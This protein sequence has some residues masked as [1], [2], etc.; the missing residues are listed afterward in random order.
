MTSV[1][2]L[3]LCALA[4]AGAVAMFLELEQGFGGIVRISPQPMRQAVKTLQTE[5]SEQNAP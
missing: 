2:T 5:P 1:I 3:T 4:V